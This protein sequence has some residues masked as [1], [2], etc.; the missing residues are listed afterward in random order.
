MEV[1]VKEVETLNNSVLLVIDKAIAFI[2]LFKEEVGEEGTEEY[3][4]DFIFPLENAL[5]ELN[6]LVEKLKD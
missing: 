4:E 1:S 6:T 2:D 3:Q 5:A